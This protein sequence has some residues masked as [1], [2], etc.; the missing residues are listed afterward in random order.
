VC[1]KGTNNRIKGRGLLKDALS[2][3]SLVESIEHVQNLA[4]R[5]DADSIKEMEVLVTKG[6][7]WSTFVDKIWRENQKNS[8]QL[9]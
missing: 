4:H 2:K 5:Q 3:C 9:T 8:Y 1:G 6:K 7:K